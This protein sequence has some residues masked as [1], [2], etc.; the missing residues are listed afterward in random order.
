MAYV[1]TEPCIRCRYTDCVAVCP[2]DAFRLGAN[3]LVIHPEECIDCGACEPECPN[4]AIY[5]ET[6]VPEKWAK[7][8]ELNATYAEKW[9]GISEQRA[10]LPDADKWKEVEDKGDLF[11]PN[12]GS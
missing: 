12:P 4:S 6:E 9:P 3:M 2:V 5:E 7:Y 1:V 11:D 10:A 8:T